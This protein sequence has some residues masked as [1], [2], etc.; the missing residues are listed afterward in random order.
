MVAMGT[1]V[2]LNNDMSCEIVPDKSAGKSLNSRLIASI[3]LKLHV[4]KAG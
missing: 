4:F 1:S 2:S 3:L